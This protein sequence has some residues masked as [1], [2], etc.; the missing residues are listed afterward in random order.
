M[1]KKYLPITL[2]LAAMLNVVA[3][4]QTA[5][6]R[7]RAPKF[8]SRYTEMAKD[9]K[10]VEEE[11]EGIECKYVGRYHVIAGYGAVTENVLVETRDAHVTIQ[12]SPTR[13][14]NSLTRGAGIIEWRLANGKPFAVIARFAFFDAAKVLA[15]VDRNETAFQESFKLG[16]VLIVKGLEGY[17]DIDFEVDPKTPNA[18]AR[19]RELADGAYAKN[20]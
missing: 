2:F 13:G 5:P 19:A 4:S 16:E 7:R 11:A 14:E 3:F 17:E 12:L 15:A 10:A 9:C 6:D 1:K 8:S 20:R 18:N